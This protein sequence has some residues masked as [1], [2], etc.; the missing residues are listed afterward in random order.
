MHIEKKEEYAIDFETQQKI[1]QLLMSSFGQFPKD[2]IFLKQVP[3]FRLLVWEDKKLV[4]QAGIVYRIMSLN[5]SPLKVFGIMD[6]CVDADYQNQK[7]GSNLLK[8]IE[9]IAIENNIDFILLFGDTNNFYLQNNF[10]LMHNNCRWVLI[11]EYVTMG[12]MT[13][14]IPDTL[15]VKS[16]S[17]EKWD[18]EAL[19]D[20]MGFIF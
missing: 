3:S 6:L 5:Q 13:R 9:A 16:I 4:A 1:H 7:I 15:L 20:I 18:D 12:I 11:K 19:L 17:G 8:H 10:Q 14:P 2:R